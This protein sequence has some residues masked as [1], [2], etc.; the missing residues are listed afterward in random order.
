MLET[1]GLVGV[2][3]SWGIG[4]KPKPGDD[5]NMGS[6]RGIPVGVGIAACG[7]IASGNMCRESG[8]KESL[9]GADKE[10]RRFFRRFIT[11]PDI[12][13]TEIPIWPAVDTV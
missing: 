9:D 7:K 3:V 4:R 12:L 13:I 5:A 11:S 2:G 10:L 8:D 6:S 1:A